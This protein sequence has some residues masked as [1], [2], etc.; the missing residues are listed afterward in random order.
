MRAQAQLR[1]EQQPM[2]MQTRL[3]PIRERVP[4]KPGQRLRQASRL[5]SG[6]ILRPATEKV[7]GLLERLPQL[8]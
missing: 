8:H 1:V 3:L 4:A 2:Q 7:P 5:L 6:N